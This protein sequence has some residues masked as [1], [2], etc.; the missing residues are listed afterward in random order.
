MFFSFI[1]PNT[2]LPNSNIND[3][4][5][6]GEAVFLI[7]CSILSSKFL[8]ISSPLAAPTNKGANNI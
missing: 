2:F 1:Y 5:T 4:P 3:S 8:V 7:T 6:K